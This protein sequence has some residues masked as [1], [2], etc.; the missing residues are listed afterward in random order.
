MNKGQST[1]KEQLGLNTAHIHC[2][3]ACD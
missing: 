2:V 3:L 1:V